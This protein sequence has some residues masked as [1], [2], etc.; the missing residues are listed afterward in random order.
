MRDK[1]ERVQRKRDF[2]E[3]RGRSADSKGRH[4][5][6]DFLSALYAPQPIR[7]CHESHFSG[8]GAM[9]RPQAS[10]NGRYADSPTTFNA[11]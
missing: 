3:H 5:L 1:S 2:E 9:T 11:I 4:T 6:V 7:K 8:K 10:A